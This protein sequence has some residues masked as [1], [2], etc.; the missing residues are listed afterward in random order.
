MGESISVSAFVDILNETL[1]FAYPELVIGGEVSG[2][3][4]NQGKWAFFDI[5]DEKS[6]L[7]CFMP[8]WLLKVPIEDGM[9]VRITG[10]PKLLASG[11]FSFTVK[12]LDLAGEGELKRAFVLLKAK[13][14]KEGLFDPARR[15][16]LP[17]FP[18]RIGL[19]TSVNSAAY[20]DF[21]KILGERW[22][23]LDVAVA[24]VVVQGP[25]AP[26][27]VVAALG[28]LNSLPEPL[29]VLVLVRGGGS[30]EDLAAFSTE[31]VARAV[32]A[33]R[34][35]IIVGVGHEVDISL[36]DLAAD[37]RAATPTDA[38]RLVVP[39]RRQIAAQVAHLQQNITQR[40]EHRFRVVDNQLTH[41]RTSLVRFIE[42]PIAVIDRA[43][44]QLAVRFQAS[45][46]S[47]RVRIES[48]T[49]LLVGLDPR[50]TLARGYAIVRSGGKIV[51]QT[52]GL[53]AGDELVIQLAKGS[54]GAEVHES[55]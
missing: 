10:S 41:S 18:R 49:R 28:H 1:T 4:L 20:H 22:G 54:I 6:T 55:N 14:E 47:S 46:V 25:S 31:P 21:T 8:V 53:K 2:Y 24:D 19:V 45:L 13:L 9:K 23:G 34:T 52:T 39:D 29:D 38:A 42:W 36:A 12:S 32:A 30:L 44:H 33:S 35:P 48:L 11:R 51:R 27:S 50:A 15:R 7:S 40:F 5:K 43:E 17:Q 16:P 37:V 3:K 26:D